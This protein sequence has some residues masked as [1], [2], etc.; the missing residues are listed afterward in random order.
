MKKITIKRLIKK[1]V[2]RIVKSIKVSRYNKYFCNKAKSFCNMEPIYNFGCKV[3][4]G[5]N[6][7]FWKGV[8]F[9]GGGTIL[10]GDRCVVGDNTILFSCGEQPKAGIYFGNDVSV[11]ANCAFYD[12]D[13]GIKLGNNINKQDSSFSPIIIEDD[14][15]L[16]TGCIILKGSII[17]KGAVIGAGSVVKGEIPENAVAVG[18]PAKVIKYRE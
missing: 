14:V 18:I 5:E 1:T 9:R 11:A 17:R 13:H 4:I 8:T 16:G 2:N 6:C 10:F 7:G 3:T 12:L 15:W